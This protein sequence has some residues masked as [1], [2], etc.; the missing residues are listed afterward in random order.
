MTIV[1]RN[2]EAIIRQINT[3]LSNDKDQQVHH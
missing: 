1:G 3:N 2:T